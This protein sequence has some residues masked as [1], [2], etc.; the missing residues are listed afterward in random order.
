MTIHLR[1]NLLYTVTRYHIIV[2][3]HTCN[4]RGNMVVKCICLIAVHVTPT[5]KG[6][7]AQV[8]GCEVKKEKINI[9]CVNGY[10]KIV[11]NLHRAV[12]DKVDDERW[13]MLSNQ[14]D[15]QVYLWRIY[16]TARWLH[17]S[18]SS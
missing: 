7:F 2:H 16:L 12:C 8:S 4:K 18:G 10:M 3:N 17:N 6:L 5:T 14:R 11:T 13:A 15:T 9:L 1:V